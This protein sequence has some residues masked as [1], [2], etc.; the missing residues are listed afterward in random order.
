[1]ILEDISGIVN[2]DGSAVA[3]DEG[4]GCEIMTITLLTVLLKYL[5]LRLP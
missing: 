3:K 1:M 5:R 4:T 2:L